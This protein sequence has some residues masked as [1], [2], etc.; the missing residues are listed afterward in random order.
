MNKIVHYLG[1]DVHKESVARVGRRCSHR[2]VLAIANHRLRNRGRRPARWDSGALPW[3]LGSQREGEAWKAGQSKAE[4]AAL[5]PRTKGAPA[6][7][8]RLENY[9]PEK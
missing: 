6:L 7:Q 3:T 4:G 9:F 1:L 8:G 5:G 2:V